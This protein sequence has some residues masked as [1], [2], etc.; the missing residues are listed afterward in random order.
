LASSY[1]VGTTTLHMGITCRQRRARVELYAPR[2]GHDRMCTETTRTLC[3]NDIS[4]KSRRSWTRL[5]RAAPRIVT[6]GRKPHAGSVARSAIEPGTIARGA[7]ISCAEGRPSCSKVGS[8]LQDSRGGRVGHFEM[9]LTP[10]LS[11][12]HHRL[13]LIPAFWWVH[14]ANAFRRRHA[15]ARARP[16]DG[17]KQEDPS[18][19]ST[20]A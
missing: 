11:R 17:V 14:S 2:P 10:L 18:L 20:R 7:N 19:P 8:A 13:P 12:S 1:R 6:E 5:A 3:A 15:P 9:M 16:A 4:C